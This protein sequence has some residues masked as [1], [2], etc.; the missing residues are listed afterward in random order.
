MSRRSLLLILLLPLAL[1]AWWLWRGAA[2]PAQSGVGHDAAKSAATP[3][4]TTATPPNPPAAAPA[5]ALGSLAAPIPTTQSPVA[6]GSVVADAASARPSSIGTAPRVT[7]AA[8]GSATAG[9]IVEVRV[10]VDLPTPARAVIA[11]V[12]FDPAILQLAEASEGELVTRPGSE[13]ALETRQ[14][15]GQ[16]DLTA[17]VTQG[18]PLEG[19]GTLAVLAFNVLQSGSLTLG[20][21]I[22]ATAK[23]P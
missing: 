5:P 4:P 8:P 12:R 11:S 20:A 7:L 14:A 13:R 21:S 10:D 9:G 23:G 18:S 1:V 3:G 22:V 6:T 16:V 17:R 15:A 19:G 2:P